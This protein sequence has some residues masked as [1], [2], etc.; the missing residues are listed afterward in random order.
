MI[1]EG[2]QRL[3]S[4]R[5]SL[6]RGL[7]VWCGSRRLLIDTR[8]TL[9]VVRPTSLLLP[10]EFPRSYIKW[11]RPKGSVCQ[12]LSRLLIDRNSSTVG[13]SVSLRRKHLAIENLWASN[14]NIFRTFRH[15][16]RQTL[17]SC[18]DFQITHVEYHSLRLIFSVRYKRQE[19]FRG[20]GRKSRW[21]LGLASICGLW[22]FTGG[23]I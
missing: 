5:N 7:G 1:R 16:S 22:P 2:F 8:G 4:R 10:V 18:A 6:A 3:T 19:I 11:T 13:A 12:S 23:R 20:R 15:V 9:N 21:I 14:S 17:E